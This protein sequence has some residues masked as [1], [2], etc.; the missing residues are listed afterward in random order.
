MYKFDFQNKVKY[1]FD[2]VGEY[3]SFNDQPAI[4]Y[5][6]GTKIW[7]DHGIMHRDES[8]GPAFQS[9]NKLEYYKN[10]KLHCD[11]GPAVIYMSCY[12][13][14]IDLNNLDPDHKPPN[15]N[16]DPPICCYYKD[17]IFQKEIKLGH[18]YHR[19][20]GIVNDDRFALKN[21][22]KTIGDISRTIIERDEY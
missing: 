11:Q 6:E 18:N 9:K 14:I 19:Y 22:S 1:L 21:L 17:G 4:E 3:H 10:G 8:C 15:Y 13:L 2:S 12:E 16:I 20:L 5:F 7:M